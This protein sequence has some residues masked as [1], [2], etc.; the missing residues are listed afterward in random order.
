MISAVALAA[1]R[2][3]WRIVIYARYSTDEQNEQSLADQEAV[4]RKA[5]DRCGL[6]DAEI[7]VLSEAAVSGEMANRPGMDR[8]WELIETQACDIIVAEEVS[9]F[10][11]HTT[12][13][14]QF[15][16]SAI[17]AGIRV[18]TLND[19]IDTLNDEWRLNSHFA[20]LKAELDNRQTRQ[21]IQRSMVSALGEGV[22]GPSHAL[23]RL[24]AGAGRGPQQ[25][26]QG[27]TAGLHPSAGLPSKISRPRA[28]R[29]QEGRRVDLRDPQDVRNVRRGRTYLG[30]RPPSPGQRNSAEFPGAGRRVDRGGRRQNDAQPH[31][32]G[33]GGVPALTQKAAVRAG[34]KH[35]G[36]NARRPN[37]APLRGALAPRPGLALA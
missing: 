17:D 12:R 29:R 8:L 4:C 19:P 11:R 7:E 30:H 34:Q 2:R 16:E 24:P 26:G 13:A 37:L 10:Y 14:M 22:R 31:L 18:I 36:S 21:R 1:P 32:P 35:C 23:T 27:P 20:S 6:A 9:R 33:R 28:F 3:R 5:I 15:I 25:S